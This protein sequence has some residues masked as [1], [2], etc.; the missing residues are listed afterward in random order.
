MAEKIN[1]IISHTYTIK[2]IR[3]IDK[4]S[5]NKLFFE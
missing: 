5:E 4:L 1:G 2:E 3:E